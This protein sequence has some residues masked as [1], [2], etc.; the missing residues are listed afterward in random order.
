MPEDTMKYGFNG[1]AMNQV[2]S[3]HPL[4][5]HLIN[6]RANYSQYVYSKFLV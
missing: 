4:H 6:V 3:K 1:P 5:Q 2:K